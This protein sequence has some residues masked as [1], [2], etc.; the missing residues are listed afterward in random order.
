[1]ADKERKVKQYKGMIIAEVTEAG[2][3]IYY[4]IYTADEWQFGKGYRYEEWEAGTI[5]EAMDF[6][7]S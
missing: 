3:P 5:K 7:D 2:K 1:M 4:K 6:I